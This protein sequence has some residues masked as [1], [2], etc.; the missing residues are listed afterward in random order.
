M[1]ET[2]IARSRRRPSFRT[3]YE[4]AA[5][6]GHVALFIPSLAL[7]MTMGG[8]MHSEPGSNPRVPLVAAVLPEAA[9][10]ARDLGEIVDRLDAHDVFGH[11]VAELTLD[12]E[13]EAARRARP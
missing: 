2:V 7:A 13:P 10:T 9:A 12:P 5:N 3:G 6:Q 4:D 8:S 11:L 1:D